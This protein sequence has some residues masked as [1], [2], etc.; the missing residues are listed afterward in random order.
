MDSPVPSWGA[1][2][3]RAVH[4]AAA[5]APAE[6]GLRAVQAGL[7]VAVEAILAGHEEVICG[8]GGKALSRLI[9]RRPVLNVLDWTSYSR[10]TLRRPER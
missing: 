8:R 3:G 10:Q 5:E 9:I 4:A 2:A 7:R 6:L 1:G